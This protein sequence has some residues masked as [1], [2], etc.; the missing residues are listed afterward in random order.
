MNCTTLGIDVT[1]DIFQ[2]H[3][4]DARGQ[5]LPQRVPQQMTRDTCSA[6]VLYRESAASRASET[7]S[8]VGACAPALLSSEHSLGTT[9]QQCPLHGA[10]LP[11]DPLK[12]L[13][14]E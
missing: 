1:K 14:L 3:S 12:L 13:R 5:V 9:A 7:V 2:L 6:V 11:L 8:L 4:V 10:V